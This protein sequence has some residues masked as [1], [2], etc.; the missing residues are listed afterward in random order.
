[1]TLPG[2][3]TLSYWFSYDAIAV[4]RLGWM[5][6]ALAFIAS[7]AATLMAWVYVRGAESKFAR[8]YWR[9]VVAMTATSTALVAVLAFFSWQFVPVLAARAWWIVWFGSMVAWAFVLWR[10][11]QRLQAELLLREARASHDGRHPSARRARS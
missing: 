1:M 11:Y 4:S 9:R 6:I 10:A 2:F 8:R 3:L 5:V 7:L